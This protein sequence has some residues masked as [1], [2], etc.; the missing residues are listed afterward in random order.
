M[1][2]W[3]HV[4]AALFERKYATGAQVDPLP[5]DIVGAFLRLGKKYEITTLYEDAVGRLA[6][7]IPSSFADRSRCNPGERTRIQIKSLADYFVI[8]SLA[9]EHDLFS[10]L[11]CALYCCVHHCVQGGDW[12]VMRT[13]LRGAARDDG[14]VVEL[15]YADKEVCLLGWEKIIK[16]QGGLY[17]WVNTE[18]VSFRCTSPDACAT[19]RA[20]HRP[21][22]SNPIQSCDLF[23][24]W[25]AS[26]AKELCKVCAKTGEKSYARASLD[27]WNELPLAFELQSWK[28]LLNQD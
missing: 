2:D 24:P 15:S 10:I 3:G 25:K 26:W 14:S 20:L 18:T 7:E 13:F 8:V 21:S 23:S 16:L 9:R 17:Q 4:L 22:G 5:L 19:A 12:E 28:V 6:Y 27:A 1:S 11:P